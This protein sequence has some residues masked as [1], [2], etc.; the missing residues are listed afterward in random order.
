MLMSSYA[1]KVNVKK[2]GFYPALMFY[3]LIHVNAREYTGTLPYR[4]IKKLQNYCLKK[5]YKFAYDNEFGYR[6]AD[7]RKTFFDSQKPIF[8]NFY[9]CAY[10][11]RLVRK[12]K[13][14]VDHV[15]PINKVKQDLKFQEKLRRNGYTGVNCAKNLVAACKKCN[16]KK[17]TKTGI[18]IFKAYI[19]KSNLYWTTRW[20][21]RFAIVLF[22]L[23][24]FISQK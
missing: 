1:V 2:S 20:L 21:F 19:G 14:T 5:H 17:G 4:K 10:C 12:K 16:L 23:Y 3:G 24:I 6:S 13:I 22:V 18:W 15:Y 7:Y 8:T 11:G 9:Y